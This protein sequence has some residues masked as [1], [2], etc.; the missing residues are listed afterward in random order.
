MVE[1]DE[2]LK[3]IFKRDYDRLCYLYAKANTVS[4]KRQFISDLEL[5]EEFYLDMIDATERFP[6]SDDEE[7]EKNFLNVTSIF[8]SYIVENKEFLLEFVEK[9]FNIFLE[10]EYSLYKDFWKTH[11]KISEDLIYKYLL[12][13]FKTIDKTM[14]DRFI[15][16]SV[17]KQLFAIEGGFF[18]FSGAIYPME[19]LDKNIIVFNTGENMTIEDAITLSHEMGHDFD[20]NNL[21]KNGCVNRLS[22]TRRTIYFEVASSFFEYAFINYLIDNR[23]YLE[24]ALMSRRNFLKQIFY[25]L[26]DMLILFHIN[27]KGEDEYFEIAIVDDESKDYA[28]GLLEKMNSCSGLFEVEDEIDY[29]EAFIYGIGGLLGIYLYESYKENP[30]TFLNDFK[31]ALLEYKDNGI[32]AFEHLGITKDKLVSGDVLRKVLRQNK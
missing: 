22:K 27:N 24:D 8:L 10:E 18:N 16:K 21:K 15:S 20:Y 28:N 2:F 7:I 12:D 25:Y 5:F 6:W 32:V 23:I 26:R 29:E 17:N 19:S 1:C 4:K 31:L 30:K 3:G 11:H 9:S 14:V 13:F